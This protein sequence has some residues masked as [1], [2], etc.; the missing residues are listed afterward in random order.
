MGGVAKAVTK[1]VKETVRVG[2]QLVDFSKALIKGT[3]NVVLAL[4]RVD[5]L[6]LHPDEYLK[7]Y[8][9][10]NFKMFAEPLAVFTG[11]D[12]AYQAVYWGTIA[13]ALVVA[14]YIGPEITALV[15]EIAMMAIESMAP[16]MMG[17]AILATSVYATISAASMV[18]AAFL[19]SYLMATMIDEVSQSYFVAMYGAQQIFGAIDLKRFSE[20]D[21]SAMLMD[22][23]MF[24]WL[25][26]GSALNAVMAGGDISAPAFAN[27]PYTKGLMY[28]AKGSDIAQGVRD[29]MP[30]EFLAGGA[31]FGLN[32][33]GGT[34]YQPLMINV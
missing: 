21:F 31:M 27:D 13:A 26:G 24:E 6:I 4:S 15:D 25:A 20:I 8:A 29:L 5:K 17:S 11:R 16:Y 33:S 9:V 19:D 12:F 7:N 28:E 3:A 30:Y 14:W 22:G 1:A 34:P 18:G 23:S 32:G 10:E 2:K